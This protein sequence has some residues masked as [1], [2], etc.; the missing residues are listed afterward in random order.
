MCAQNNKGPYV[1]QAPSYKPPALQH[2]S[3]PGDI[4]VIVKVAGHNPTSIMLIVVVPISLRRHTKPRPQHYLPPG[5]PP[6][7]AIAAF[8]SW[9]RSPS[10]C[11]P[12]MCLSTH[13]MTQLSSREVSDLLSKPLT[14]WSKQFWTRF[15]YICGPLCQR[16]FFPVT[17]T[18]ARPQVRVALTFMNSFIC[19]FSMRVCSSRCSDAVSLARD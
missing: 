3:M 12:F 10:R 1:V 13:R 9:K 2:S 14:Q 5:R 6:C 11:E 15:E 18:A 8:C 7:C 4:E 19:F 17:S 16:Q